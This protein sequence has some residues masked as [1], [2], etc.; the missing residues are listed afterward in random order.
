MVERRN[1][2][3]GYRQRVQS[4]HKATA[5]LV[6]K[7]TRSGTVLDVGCGVGN[8]LQIIHRLN[9]RLVLYGA[10]IDPR[11]LELAREKVDQLN[12][13]LIPE[14]EDFRFTSIGSTFQTC[15][16]S[17]SL[18]HMEYPLQAVRDL[19]TLI[20]PGGHLVLATPNPVRPDVFWKSLSR[21]HYVNRGHIQAWDR[22]HWMNFIERIAKL[23]AVEYATDEVRVFP[24]RFSRRIRSLQSIEEELTRVFPHWSFS[25]IVVIQK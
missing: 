14:S 19:M 2:H 16:L 15:L 21:M 1:I 3:T 25:N 5:L 11:C 24:R 7:Y 4:L 13:I 6:H 20:R 23:N 10:D 12:T 22:S 8:A 17:H 18:E 9:P